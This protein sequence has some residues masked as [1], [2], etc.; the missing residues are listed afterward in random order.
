MRASAV[1]AHPASLASLDVGTPLRLINPKRS[2]P[3]L[4]EVVV[5]RALL[6]VMIWTLAPALLRLKEIKVQV[7]VRLLEAR[8]EV[9]VVEHA[10]QV[11]FVHGL[12]LHSF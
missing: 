6:L 4:V 7:L 9:G 5:V 8:L 12:G 10:D 3:V 2:S 1:V 11:T